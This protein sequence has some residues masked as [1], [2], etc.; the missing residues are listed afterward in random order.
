MLESIVVSA[1]GKPDKVFGYW[2]KT[3]PDDSDKPGLHKPYCLPVAELWRGRWAD[4]ASQFALVESETKFGAA[5]APYEV[6]PDDVENGLSRRLGD[7]VNQAGTWVWLDLDEA[8]PTRSAFDKL[9]KLLESLRLDFFW[10]T[11]WS[12]GKEGKPGFRVR[13]IIRAD[14]LQDAPEIKNV[15]L[16]LNTLLSKALG[17][18]SGLVDTQAASVP[19]YFNRAGFPP[20]RRSHAFQ[21]ASSGGNCL[22]LDAVLS[23]FAPRERFITAVTERAEYGTRDPQLTR[24]AE[25]DLAETLAE[26]AATQSVELRRRFREQMFHLGNLVAAGFLHHQRTLD[27]V[28]EALHQRAKN[29]R[30]DH[31]ATERLLDFKGLIE[32]GINNGPKM[33]RGYGSDGSL[34]HAQLSKLASQSRMSYVEMLQ[35]S[36]PE[37]YH[38]REQAAE[39]IRLQMSLPWDQTRQLLTA[40]KITTGTGKSHVADAVISEQAE[41]LKRC[42]VVSVANHGLAREH[43]GRITAKTFHM[44]G[45]AQPSSVTGG[46]ECKR[47]QDPEFKALEA[48]GGVRLRFLCQNCPFAKECKVKDRQPP[49]DTQVIVCTHNQVGAAMEWFS[50]QG[51]NARLVIDEEPNRPE[52]LII[53]VAYGKY[54]LEHLNGQ[55]PIWGSLTTGQSEQLREYLACL[56]Y[57]H[58]KPSA[59]LVESLAAYKGTKFPTRE[60]VR[61]EDRDADVFLGW[62]LRVAEHDH[63]RVWSE[64]LGAWLCSCPDSIWRSIREYGAV[65]LSATLTQGL[66]SEHD[67]IVDIQVQG[68]ANRILIPVKHVNRRDIT[69]NGEVDPVRLAHLLNLGLRHLPKN[70]PL[71]VCC[72]KSVCDYMRE[73]LELFAGFEQVDFTYEAKA[74]GL[75]NWVGWNVLVVGNNF[76]RPHID[77]HGNPVWTGSVAMARDAASQ[78][79]ARARATQA[80]DVIPTLIVVGLPPSEWGTDTVVVDVKLGRPGTEEIPEDVSD[81]LRTL[82]QQRGKSGT[83]KSLDVG[84]STMRRW[85]SSGKMPEAKALRLRQLLAGDER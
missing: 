69:P 41:T 47:L 59:G 33:P 83:A 66:Y 51:T 52:Q 28:R 43:V 56:V 14:R 23:H 10:S 63:R 45:I 71:L 61:P 79:A 57:R 50:D 21:G 40:L 44:Y 31:T 64:T 85:L 62:L 60:R 26:V 17:M 6:V 42:H 39:E 16:A 22:K 29:F 7:L 54:L 75:N 27:S 3:N 4:V 78:L 24:D 9:L 74:K 13:M 32:H 81:A 38:S 5:F 30:D 58:R 68:E 53:D 49:E 19:H 1:V 77:E 55:H 37:H 46:P 73:H 12:N 70:R 18:P 25:G 72:F 76:P 11:T 2:F 20:A 48:R 65:L 36:E 15:R 82:I 8:F 84:V 67:K 35:A 34:D 80:L